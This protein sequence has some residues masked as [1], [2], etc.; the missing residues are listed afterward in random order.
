M[1]YFD[2]LNVLAKWE[3][4]ET[5]PNIEQVLKIFL[6][7]H[8]SHCERSFSKLKIIKNYLR[9]T[10]SQQHTPYLAIL[11]IEHGLTCQINFDEI[12]TSFANIIVK[13]VKL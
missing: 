4:Q 9:L 11:P 1:D 6:T 7:M 12:I 13:T 8:N 2:H 5:Y 3:L 10:S